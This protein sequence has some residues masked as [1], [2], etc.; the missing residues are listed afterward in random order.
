MGLKSRPKPARLPEK[1]LYIREALRLSQGGMEQRL[2]LGAG[3]DRS[4]ISAYERGEREP[5]LPHLLAY[6]RTANVWVDVLIDDSLDLP[7]KLPS[8]KTSPGTKQA[9]SLAET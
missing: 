9:S 6:A 3:Y 7:S 4:T 2:E 1:L 8:S 5:P